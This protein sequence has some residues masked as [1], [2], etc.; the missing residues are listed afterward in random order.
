MPKRRE[1]CEVP[2]CR[3][4]KD[5]G[6]MCRGHWENLPRPVRQRVI[7]ARRAVERAAPHGRLAALAKL[8]AANNAA[9]AEAVKRGRRS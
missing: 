1:L 8:E 7:N 3:H 9:I 4:D 5:D 2:G 6:L